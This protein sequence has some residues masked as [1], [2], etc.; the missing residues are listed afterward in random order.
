[1]RA[2]SLKAWE[3]IARRLTR[4][5]MMVFEKVLTF[6]GLTQRE[7]ADKIGVPVHTISGR[8]TSLEDKKIFYVEGVKMFPSRTGRMLPHGRYYINKKKVKV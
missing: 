4:D 3:E 1:M 2:N 5:E 8:F 7:I 6:P